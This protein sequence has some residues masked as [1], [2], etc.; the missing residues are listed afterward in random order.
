MYLVCL[1]EDLKICE[2]LYNSALRLL[3]MDQDKKE[4][5]TTDVNST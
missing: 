3:K 2:Y 4:E 1:K 5:T